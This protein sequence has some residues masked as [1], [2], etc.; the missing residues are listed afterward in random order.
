MNGRHDPHTLIDTYWPP[1]FDYHDPD[2]V[3]RHRL[4]SNWITSTVGN[5]RVN[6]IGGAH[7]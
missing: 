4:G 5:F 6:L 3:G 7:G 1:A 2:Y